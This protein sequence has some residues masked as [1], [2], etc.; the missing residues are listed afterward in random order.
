MR[1]FTRGEIQKQKTVERKLE[2]DEGAKLARK[3]DVLRET[4]ASEEARLVKFKMASL[5]AT[6]AQITAAVNEREA[7]QAE[8]SALKEEKRRLEEPL[9]SEWEKLTVKQEEISFLQSQ[10]AEKILLLN[11]RERGIRAQED[12]LAFIEAEISAIKDENLKKFDHYSALIDQ[13]NRSVSDAFEA[14]AKVDRYVDDRIKDILSRETLVA[15]RERAV[16]MK[17]EQVIKDRQELAQR[18]RFINDKYETLLRTE[19]NGQRK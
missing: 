1:L 15:T 18:E 10:I 9:T 8:I 4:S 19:K 17:Q 14:K 6:Q 3:V 16:Q 12:K 7:I 2:I 11:K 13:T 5:Y